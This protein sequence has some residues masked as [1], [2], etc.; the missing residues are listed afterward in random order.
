LFSSERALALGQALRNVAAVLSLGVLWLPT[1]AARGLQRQQAIGP[2][3]PKRL[4]EANGQGNG[5][6]DGKGQGSE[7]RDQAKS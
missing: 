2:A 5:D 3:A 6:G 1:L 4:T 7:V